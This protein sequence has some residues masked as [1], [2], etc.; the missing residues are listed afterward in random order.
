MEAHDATLMKG[1]RGS[2]ARGEASRVEQGH[3]VQPGLASDPSPLSTLASTFRGWAPFDVRSPSSGPTSPSTP[4]T[5]SPGG[6]GRPASQVGDGLLGSGADD[7][8][9]RDDG[10]DCEE[11]SVP[12]EGGD[13]RIELGER[14]TWARWD[15]MTVGSETRRVL[16]LGY[17]GGGL[18]VWDCSSLDSWSEIL[19]LASIDLPQPEGTR[20][21]TSL[22]PIEVVA[23]AVL[24]APANRQ[25]DPDSQHPSLALVTR[26][27]SE[28]HSHS[29]ASHL[30]LYSLRTHRI[31]ST[32]SLPGIAHRIS[33]S[34]RFVVVSTSSPL[35]LHVYRLSYTPNSSS[36]SL[37][38]ASFSPI[39]NIAP[40]PPSSTSTGPVFSL[41][42]GG[43]LLAYSTSTPIPSSKLDRSPAR[44]GTNILA[45]KGFFEPDLPNLLASPSASS[46]IGV[47]GFAV[48]EA[49]DVARRV[50]E[51][52]MSGVNALREAGM[53]YWNQRRASEGGEAGSSAGGA[54]SR[55]APQ[56][57]GVM[58]RKMSS[59]TAT[60]P[61]S[62]YGEV[63]DSSAGT[64]VVVDLLSSAPSS[65]TRSSSRS[66]PPTAP[67]PPLKVIH[68]FRPYAHSVA[69]LSFSPSSTSLLASASTGHHF[70]IFELKPA[71]PVGTSATS[72]PSTSASPIASSGLGK[73]W[74]RH[75]LQRGFTS[76][77]TVESSWSVDGRFVA[78]STG[79]GTAH[80]YAVEPN[81][82]VPSLEDH[83]Q[84]KV[85]NAQELPGLSVPLSSVARIRH[86]LLAA[87]TIDEGARQ[88]LRPGPGP[89]LPVSIAFLPKHTS[90]SSSLAPSPTNK[91]DLAPPSQQ[92]LL[93]FRP[94]LGSS[95]LY[96]LTPVEAA[97]L[98]SATESAVRGDVGK[99]AT[100]AVSGLT[101]MMK[102]RG[103]GLLK[104]GLGGL[105]RASEVKEAKKSWSVQMEAVAEWKLAREEG[106]P[107]VREE[108][109]AAEVGAEIET[110]SRSPLVLPRSIYRSQQFDFFSL[111]ADHEA[112]AKAGSSALPLR[113]LEVRSEVQ[114]RP[115][116]GA[117][118]SDVSPSLSPALSARR[119]STY[120]ASSSFEPASFDQPIKNAMQTFLEAE[121]MLAPG[122]PNLP[123]P[124]FPNG[125]PGKH[126]SWR[127]SIPIPRKVGPAAIEGIGKVRQGLGQIRVPKG[128]MSLPGR[129]ASSS[130]SIGQAP[131]AYSSSLSFEDDDA[132]FADHA[133]A[134]SAST[135]YTSDIDSCGCVIKGDGE[136][137]PPAREEE[138][139]GWDDRLDEP[140]QTSGT[141]TMKPASSALDLATPFEDDFD[142]FELE[143]P[144][145]SPLSLKPAS[146]AV[147]SPL[148]LEPVDA[149]VKAHLAPP[150]QVVY[151][152][153]M[154]ATSS[155]ASSS[156]AG[157]VRLDKSR[158]AS[159]PRHLL[160]QPSS[161]LSS[162]AIPPP[163]PT[164]LIAPVN[165]AG[166]ASP[167]LSSG[168]SSGSGK[169]KKR[170]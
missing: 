65:T 34:R 70:D 77:T 100:T 104:D 88:T 139:W 68:H 91:R 121:A 31:V 158:T 14:I 147:P 82:G 11:D 164:G 111:P 156:P 28:S 169:K 134:A 56:Q 45:H 87:Q 58:G 137:A 152:T 109:L 54:L 162:V 84:P 72:S 116:E 107:E 50:G 163:K 30:S 74:H 69:H 131:A 103:A 37:E 20:K 22:Q 96:R 81:G 13:A 25:V 108:V 117:V 143:L 140:I 105:T 67:L 112:Y 10:S 17:R 157:H 101:Q 40:P 90:L 48:Q 166:N 75:R 92:D 161:V 66:A 135:A 127:D 21:K 148:T 149:P 39:L 24:P 8:L 16:I 142:H 115:V 123:T 132:V 79:K 126:G 1:Q 144:A 120:S 94:S 89:V 53:S 110:F 138:D 26:S 168:S 99:L 128:I 122:S 118:S 51:G 41:G 5:K 119:Y 160:D 129:R 133:V 76:A 15:E 80:V 6:P 62:G 36:P 27:I 114:I 86:P 55:S 18:A 59:P 71:V 78:V 61:S 12:K 145:A 136:D 47:A 95:T 93:I 7:A 98:A 29:P 57:V 170:R 32:V 113:R 23:A 38:P 60:R 4:A 52:V 2:G 146:L 153:S 42:S 102:T 49:P 125:V 83:F 44:P 155:S 63:E 106:W 43:R 165:N 167:A 150:V 3:A 64:I 33:T 97:P 35:A 159:P 9:M 154:D 130:T 141:T 124:T 19:N 73:V 151:S 85:A 46:A